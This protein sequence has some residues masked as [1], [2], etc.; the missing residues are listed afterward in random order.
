MVDARLPNG[1]RVNATIPPLALDGPLLTIRKFA[2]DPLTLVV[3]FGSPSPRFLFDYLTFKYDTGLKI[4]P[5]H[6]FRGRKLADFDFYDPGAGWPF[7]TG[8]YRVTEIDPNAGVTLAKYE[9]FAPT[10]TWENTSGFSAQISATC[11]NTA[12]SSLSPYPVMRFPDCRF[13]P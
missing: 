5:E 6:V 9:N 10:P 1:Y 11:S 13:S 12:T 4:L 3:R 7:G 8:P 2:A